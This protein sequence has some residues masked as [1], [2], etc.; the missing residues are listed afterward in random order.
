LF[1]LQIYFFIGPALYKK[2]QKNFIIII[3]ISYFLLIFATYFIQEYLL[4]QAWSFFL[5]F[6]ENSNNFNEISGIEK[7]LSYIPSLGH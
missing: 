3:F 7:N 2:E 1:W 4:P 6:G 5:S